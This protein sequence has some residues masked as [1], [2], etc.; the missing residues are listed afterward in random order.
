[1]N[2]VQQ[3]AVQRVATIMNAA[4][5]AASQSIHQALDL[6]T[7]RGDTQT[8]DCLID[9]LRAV[10]AIDERAREQE[11]GAAQEDWLEEVDVA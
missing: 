4:M 10:S 3:A 6:A 1:M 2:A 5:I 9:L 11:I 8:A 7:G